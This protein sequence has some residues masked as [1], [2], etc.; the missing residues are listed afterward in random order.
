MSNESPSCDRSTISRPLPRY[1]VRPAPSLEHKVPTKAIDA[2]EYD[3][4]RRD[5]ERHVDEPEGCGADGG[6]VWGEWAVTR[7]QGAG[8]ASVTECDS[9]EEAADDQARRSSRSGGSIGAW[10]RR[11]RR[12]CDH[13]AAA[14]ALELKCP[15]EPPATAVTCARPDRDSVIPVTLNSAGPRSGAVRMHAP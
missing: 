13:E 6:R 3:G 14:A 10:H 2:R 1:D 4:S 9:N 7:E 5:G 15:G 12:P 11:K 8:G